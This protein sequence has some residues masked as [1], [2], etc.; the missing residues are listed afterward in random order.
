V[1]D[2]ILLCAHQYRYMTIY[3]IIPG[4]DGCSFNIAIAGSNG[5]RQTM[6]GFPT[7]AEAQA[8]ISQDKRLDR[9]PNADAPI[10]A[11]AAD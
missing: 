11:A 10:T 7:E 4:D 6:L 2:A 5:A 9:A 1:P 8:W 3:S